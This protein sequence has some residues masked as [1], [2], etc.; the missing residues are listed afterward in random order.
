MT[1]HE[2]PSADLEHR[3]LGDRIELSW[4]EKG[5][6]RIHF[7]VERATSKAIAGTGTG[8]AVTAA[9]GRVLQLALNQIGES[10]LGATVF[11]RY[12]R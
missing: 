4:T 2:D 6:R 3:D 9:D 5:N 7:T 12:S 10:E 11:D 1:S 8:E